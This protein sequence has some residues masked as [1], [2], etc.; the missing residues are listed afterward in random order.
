MKLQNQMHVVQSR[1][2]NLEGGTGIG[3]A[4]R[5]ACTPPNKA[6]TL[7]I[8]RVLQRHCSNGGPDGYLRGETT[9]KE[10][11]QQKRKVQTQAFR[12]RRPELTVGCVRSVTWQKQ[13]DHYS[14]PTITQS[15]IW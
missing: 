13:Y 11:C 1:I 15:L 2:I 8:S 14:Y 6:A 9:R 12:D 10:N 5:A 7:H 4:L 3:I